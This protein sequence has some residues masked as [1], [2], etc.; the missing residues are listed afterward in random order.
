LHIYRG[1]LNH[2]CNA[3]NAV[4]RLTV[5]GDKAG[6]ITLQKANIGVRNG[7]F[8]ITHQKGVQ[9]STCSGISDVEPFLGCTRANFGTLPTEKHNSK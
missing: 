2:Y 6:T 1:L 5:T 9:Y 7:Y 3:D 8:N 4:L